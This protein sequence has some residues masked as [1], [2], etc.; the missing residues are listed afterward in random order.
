MWIVSFVVEDADSTLNAD[1]R[2]ATNQRSLLLSLTVEGDQMP[3]GVRVWDD[4]S[5]EPVEV[6]YSHAPFPYLL[7]TDR[8][9]VRSLHAEAFL[10]Q[11]ST[12]PQAVESILYDHTP[13]HLEID[14]DGLPST[15]QSSDPVLTVRYT[16]PLFRRTDPDSGLQYVT[17]YYR[18]FGERDWVPVESVS[19]GRSFTLDFSGFALDGRVYEL[20]VEGTDNAGNVEALEDGEF[21]LKYETTNSGLAWLDY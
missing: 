10:L 5:E 19:P 18:E 14:L 15:I 16:D 9:G 2:A 3:D 6:S 8:E 4:G 21:S 13:P 17:L 20:T 11:G 1:P 7:S 12:S